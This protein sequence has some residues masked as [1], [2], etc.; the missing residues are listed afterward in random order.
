MKELG[1][2][3]SESK[4]VIGEPVINLLL[5]DLGSPQNIG[6]IVR[7]S[8]V[9]AGENVRLYIY[10]PRNKLEVNRDVVDL[11]SITL[12]GEEGAYTK[13]DDLER[14]ISEYPGRIV[15]TDISEQSTSLVNF[16]FQRGD[17]LMFGNENRGY[18]DESLKEHLGI[19]HIANRLIVPMC[20]KKY[21]LPDRGKAVP[22]DHGSYP[23]L[24]VATTVAI[25]TYAAL[26]QLGGF[27][28]FSLKDL[29]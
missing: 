20:G 14:F 15:A 4:E 5:V 10:D 29:Q 26:E 11:T 23:N 3:L 9:L 24:N 13:V 27:E 18:R 25:V 12:V 6:L 22:E 16:S 7:T 17:L 28:Q 2:R 21:E 8:W 19:Q 1:H